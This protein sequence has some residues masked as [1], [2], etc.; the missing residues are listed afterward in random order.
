[1]A[2]SVQY[3]VRG[4]TV[5]V[6]S[7]L[8][9]S[10][11]AAPVAAAVRIS[12]I[13]PAPSQ[14]HEWVELHNDGSV[15]VT[16]EGWQL[17]DTLSSPSV[18]G[19]FS[20]DASI[21]AGGYLVIDLEEQKLNNS[22]DTIVLTNETGHTEDSV[23]YLTAQKDQSWALRDG[24]WSW[25]DPSPGLPTPNH[26]YSFSVRA[27][28]K[29]NLSDTPISVMLELTQINACP[30]SGSSESL[31]LMN[32][33]DTLVSIENWRVV[34]AS[35]RSAA[36]D[37]GELAPH[38]S[39]QLSW[40]QSLLNNSG[41]TLRIYDDGDRVLLEAEYASCRMGE[42]LEFDGVVWR[43]ISE[44]QAA[45]NVTL[46]HPVASETGDLTNQESERLN[47]S[48]PDPDS[49]SALLNLIS[50]PSAKYHTPSGA[51]L[52]DTPSNAITITDQSE[53]VLPA[54]FAI[55]VGCVLVSVTSAL[56]YVRLKHPTAQS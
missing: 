30:A 22:G 39:T 27:F 41:D 43:P 13:H 7:L 36:L 51:A 42:P 5:V 2:V 54:I 4:C 38:S 11:C 24:E 16:L 55:I 14:G 53:R 44:D 8:L 20:S 25:D 23:Q 40:D 29:P 15:S 32:P 28:P 31:T 21:V 47:S 33:T 37:G 1:M 34:D 48:E 45:Q 9:S 12:E 52:T 10:M 17:T 50:T 3:V 26:T 56:L 18:L 35:D 19:L 46:V 6:V 49:R